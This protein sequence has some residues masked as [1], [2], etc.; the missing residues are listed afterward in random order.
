MDESRL[1]AIPITG[2]AGVGLSFRAGVMRW[3]FN[4]ASS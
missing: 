1:Q 4:D 3:I 2:R